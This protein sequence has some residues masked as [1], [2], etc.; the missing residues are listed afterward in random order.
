MPSGHRTVGCTPA[1]GQLAR[2]LVERARERA[3]QKFPGL[4]SCTSGFA[5]IPVA[6]SNTMRDH[7]TA[8]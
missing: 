8:A 2:L 6:S 7:E 4:N 1:L 5:H 3:V